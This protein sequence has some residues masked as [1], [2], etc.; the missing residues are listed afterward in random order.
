[1]A[2]ASRHTT[3][4]AMKQQVD[5]VYE[6]GVF[7][8]L[9]PVSVAE[10]QRVRIEILENDPGRAFLDQE[11]MESARAEAEAAGQIPSIEEVRKR[12]A[13]VPGSMAETV[14]E[15]RGEF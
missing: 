11:F 5:A 9:S 14:M 15:E 4:A 8:R 13:S 2:S 6:N 7:R 10:S 3:A 1:V 12:L